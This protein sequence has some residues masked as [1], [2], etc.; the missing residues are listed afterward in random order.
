MVVNHK[1]SSGL[2]LLVP[3]CIESLIKDDY[4]K[5]MDGLPLRLHH[6]IRAMISLHFLKS[7]FTILG[8]LS[9]ILMPLLLVIVGFGLWIGKDPSLDFSRN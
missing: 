5:R 3:R 4:E 6:K 8:H 9:A 7:F 2:G 1:T